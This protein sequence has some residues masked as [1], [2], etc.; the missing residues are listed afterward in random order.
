MQAQINQWYVRWFLWNCEVL[1]KFWD[2]NRTRKYAQGT[3]LCDFFR[4]ILLGTLITMLSLAIWAYMI[5]TVFVMPFVLFNFVSVAVTVGVW[6]AAVMALFLLVIVLTTVPTVVLDAYD[7]FT[8]T[9][10]APSDKPPSLTQV[11]WVYLKG[12][13]NRFCPTIRFDKDAGL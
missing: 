2:K 8:H 5:I 1:D 3:N 13:K 4:T 11:T 6:L 12:I 9:I 10:K 7:R